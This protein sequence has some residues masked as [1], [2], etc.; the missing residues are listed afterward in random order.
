MNAATYTS[1]LFA[2]SPPPATSA[3]S[4][5]SKARRLCPIVVGGCP[6]GGTD[7]LETLVV[8]GLKTEVAP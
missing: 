5:T 3:T 8:D 4:A 7:D 2:W 6:I 1:D